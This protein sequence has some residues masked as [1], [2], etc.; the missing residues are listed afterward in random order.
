[1]AVMQAP[2]LSELPVAKVAQTALSLAPAP[3]A[4]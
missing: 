3:A 4:A 1:V 2:K